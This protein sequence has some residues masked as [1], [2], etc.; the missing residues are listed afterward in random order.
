MTV[1]PDTL[2]TGAL[3]SVGTVLLIGR[4]SLGLLDP[5]SRAFDRPC[6]PVPERGPE[7]GEAVYWD[8]RS[9]VPP[10]L[11]RVDKPKGAV[12]RHTRKYAQGML[13]EDRSFFFRGP[14]GRLNV[15][16]H[17]LGLFLQI[18]DGV[19]EGTY[20]FHLRNG[21]MATWLRTCIKDDE[22]ADEVAGIAADEGLDIATARKLVRT[23]IEQR[24]TA[25]ATS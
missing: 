23:A 12:K 2:S 4:E 20:L 25:P 10:V 9:D 17:N 11:I 6:P 8:C 22:L 14:D 16:A 1:H 24:Y 3:R 19:D 18:G 15:R 5:L 7:V 13:G 21:D